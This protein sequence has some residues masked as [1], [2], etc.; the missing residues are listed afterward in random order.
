MNEAIRYI[1]YDEAL[2]VYRKMISASNGGFSGVR[3]E[4]GITPRSRISCP[5][6]SS[7]SVQ[8]ITSRM[9]TSVSH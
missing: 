7:P 1:D 8:G 9:A 6:L 4:G 5:T 3:D 2:M